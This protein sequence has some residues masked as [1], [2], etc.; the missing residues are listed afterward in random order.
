MFGTSALTRRVVFRHGGRRRQSSMAHLLFSV[1]FE[2]NQKYVPGSPVSL[3]MALSYG[4][5]KLPLFPSRRENFR[6]VVTTYLQF[7]VRTIYLRE[8]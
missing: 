3:M 1:L 7:P 2:L 8:K 4:R 5:W 6:F